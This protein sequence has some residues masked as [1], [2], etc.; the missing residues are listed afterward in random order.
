IQ[1]L[2]LPTSLFGPGG[3]VQPESTPGV[4]APPIFLHGPQ[5]VN[6][7]FSLTKEIPIWERVGLEFHA[8]FINLFNHPNFNYTD[9]Y[10]YG[11]NNPAQ[12]LFVNSAP[13][14]QLTG[15]TPANYGGQNSP[16]QIQFRLQV[17]F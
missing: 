15:T 1:G 14:S 11:S 4:I 13:Y 3:A 6:T 16:R 17:V 9:N 8:E 7:D 2:G 5:F 10:S 12:Y